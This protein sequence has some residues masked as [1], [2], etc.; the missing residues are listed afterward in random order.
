MFINSEFNQKIVLVTQQK[1]KKN[2]IKDERIKMGKG[3]LIH[4]FKRKLNESSGLKEKQ[5][6]S[7]HY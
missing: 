6:Q 2:R 5:N 1:K 3:Y 4:L 7:S